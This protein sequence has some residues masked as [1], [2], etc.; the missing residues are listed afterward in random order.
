MG[1]RLSAPSLTMDRFVA[2]ESAYL[3]PANESGTLAAMGLVAAAAAVMAIP[4]VVMGK[5]A[6][7]E[8]KD[9]LKNR[10]TDLENRYKIKNEER[11]K[12]LIE[13]ARAEYKIDL[14]P[15]ESG[16]FQNA[17][18]L[19]VSIQKDLT[20]WLKAMKQSKLFKEYIQKRSEESQTND[21]Y[22]PMSP[23]D[24]MK[25]LEIAPGP[26]GSFLHDAYVTEWGQEAALLLVDTTDDLAA[27]LRFKYEKYLTH[28]GIGDGDEGI[29][30]WKIK[31]DA[32]N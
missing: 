12:A 26:S 14:T 25:A 27:M 10:G 29:I 13:T 7:K 2:F 24:C 9:G 1:Q 28:I 6:A 20:V 23:S 22:D 3:S 15:Y 11:R 21:F 4:A 32:F 31:D 19:K 5:R 16:V 30:S 18:Q 8:V 17:N